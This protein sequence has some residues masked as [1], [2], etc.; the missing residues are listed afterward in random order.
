MI[1]T[2]FR[3]GNGFDI[4]RLV[5]H[6]P[7]I[8]GG[9]HIKKFPLGLLGHSDADVVTHALCDALLGALA[10]SDIGTHFPD[11]DPTY[12]N[13]NSLNLLAHVSQLISK[14]K[15]TIANIDITIMAEKPNLSSYKQ[16]IAK[17]FSDVLTIPLSAISI[18]AKTHEGMGDIGKGRAIAA[19]ASVLVRSKK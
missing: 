7:L 4:H 10:L 17:N 3:I 14:K 11:T 13:M 1:R 2:P 18:K 12:K 16:K 5:K 19:M 6:R 15:Y 9:V 8:L